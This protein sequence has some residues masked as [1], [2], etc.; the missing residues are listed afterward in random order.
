MVWSIADRACQAGLWKGL[1][2]A[3]LPGAFFD[4]ALGWGNP[5]SC[6]SLNDMEIWFY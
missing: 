1:V 2:T 5:R 3:N 6:F 4:R